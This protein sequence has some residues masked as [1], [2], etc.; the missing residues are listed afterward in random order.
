MRQAEIYIVLDAQLDVARADEEELRLQVR[1]IKY[2]CF[3]SDS[4]CGEQDVVHMTRR[5][6]TSPYDAGKRREVGQ[7]RRL[8]EALR[9]SL[10][11]KTGKRGRRPQ[12]QVTRTVRV[13]E[14]K[15]WR[16]PRLRTSNNHALCPCQRE[17][18]KTF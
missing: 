6:R 14:G 3:L 2:I 17:E 5:K 13:R 15:G 10:S 8:L 7:I 11:I 16:S 9:I 12:A 1:L 18:S 4:V